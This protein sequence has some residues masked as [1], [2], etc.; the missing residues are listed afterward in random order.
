MATSVVNKEAE[1]AKGV[2]R[3]FIMQSQAYFT[4]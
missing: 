3:S 1:G 2:K 4:C